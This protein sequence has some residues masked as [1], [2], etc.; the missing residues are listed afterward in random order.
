MKGDRFT[1]PNIREKLIEL[2]ETVA[3]PK[4]LLCDGEVIVSTSQV[5][6]HLIANG[7]TIQKG[8]SVTERLP[9]VVRCGVCRYCDTA[10]CP[11]SGTPG[12]VSA[13]DFCSYGERR[14]GE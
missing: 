3:S 13:S 2:L 12:R 1:M 8:I 6:N 5:A 7:V 4:D 9:E 10:D 11:M 14:E